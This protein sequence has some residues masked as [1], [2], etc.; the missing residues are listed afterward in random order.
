VS[1]RKRKYFDDEEEKEYCRGEERK[2]R[3]PSRI[4]ERKQ[5]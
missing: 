4:L 1:R 3:G 2:L 5:R